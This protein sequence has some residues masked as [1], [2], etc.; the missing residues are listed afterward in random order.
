MKLPA[1]FSLLLTS[2]LLASAK[3]LHPRHLSSWPA[4]VREF[5]CAVSERIS[6]IAHAPA[7]TRSSPSPTSSSASLP[8]C[9]LASASLP[10]SAL[11]PP[12]EGLI[13]YHIAVGRGTQNYSC[14][15]GGDPNAAPTALGATAMLFNTS[16]LAA[17]NPNVFSL[18]PA[19]ALSVPTPPANSKVLFPAEAFLSG[20]HYFSD[21]TTAVFN[22]HT[23]T[24]NFGISFTK[25]TA[26]VTAPASTP[27]KQNVGP[28]G[29]AAVAWLKL[30]V[31]DPNG[32]CEPEDNKGI[33]E[34]Y[35]VNTQGG[36]PPK[37]CGAYGKTGTF[38]VNYS[39][40]YWFF[41]PP[42]ST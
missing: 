25:K 35:R 37:T 2:P 17:I 5:Y 31:K 7:N 1:A 8:A 12:S 4:P 40:E 38:E 16:C 33:K 39:A 13:P 29:S 21:A 41:A 9:S 18:L 28:D 11:P 20:H 26:N 34:V 36:S 10:S 19:A 14:P 24:A 30:G 6:T 27:G 22:L 15:A 3:P 42:P 32:N 23:A